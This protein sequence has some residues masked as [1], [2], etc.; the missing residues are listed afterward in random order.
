MLLLIAIGMWQKF[1]NPVSV[2]TSC[3]MW[4]V[5]D[6]LCNLCQF[7]DSFFFAP[8]QRLRRDDMSNKSLPLTL[9]KLVWR[10]FILNYQFPCGKCF[11]LSGLLLSVCALSCFIYYPLMKYSD[12]YFYHIIDASSFILLIVLGIVFFCKQCLVAWWINW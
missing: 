2:C 10:K 1:G 6:I 8:I 4:P 11:A 3:W 12:K 5:T 7:Y 9:Q